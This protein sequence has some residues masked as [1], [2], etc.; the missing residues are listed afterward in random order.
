MAAEERD[1]A[2]RKVAIAVKCLKQWQD[3]KDKILTMQ[4][5]ERKA[6]EKEEM[7]RKKAEEE[8]KLDAAKAAFEAWKARK[9]DILKEQHQKEQTAK[10]KK[11]QSEKEVAIEKE[12]S[13]KKA[14]EAWKS[15]KEENL[16]LSSSSLN[17]SSSSLPTRPAWCPARSIKYDTSAQGKAERTGSHKHRQAKTQ[18]RAASKPTSQHAASHVKITEDGTVLKQKTIHVCCQ[19]LQ[20]WCSCP[21]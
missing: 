5:K 18:Q 14:F 4:H 12:S 2:E 6:K 8:E 13:A 3:N 21:E 11:E 1:R 7:E 9:S 10:R 19:T 15:R 17:S 16:S 20:Y